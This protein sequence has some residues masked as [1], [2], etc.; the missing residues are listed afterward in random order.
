MPDPA[1]LRG[2][3]AVPPGRLAAYRIAVQVL[4]LAAA[5]VV[6]WY[7]SHIPVQVTDSLGNM[8]EARVH[9]Y[10]ALFVDQLLAK[11]FLRPLLWIQIKGAYDLAAGH[12][13]LTFKTIHT[14]QLVAAAVLLVR[15]CR[16]QSFRDAAY[17]P[18]ILAVLFGVH[19]FEGTVREAHPINSFLSVVVAVLAAMN[20][21]VSRPAWWRDALA[22]LLLAWMALVVETGL[23]VAVAVVAGWLV[24]LRGVSRW[25]VAGCVGLVAAYALLRFGL[26]AN[27]LPGLVERST[28]FGFGVLDP[29]ELIARFGE[30]RWQLYA[31]NVLA[32]L[33]TV[34][35]SE[36]RGGVFGLSKRVMD[37][38]EIPWWMVTDVA[39][40]ALTTLVCA[41]WLA[42]AVRRWR[43]GRLSVADQLGLVGCAVL[44]ANAVL[45]YGYT[46]D[47]IMSAGGGVFAVIVCAALRPLDAVTGGAWRR[48]AV[49]AVVAVMATGW[50]VRAAAL[51]VTLMTEAFKTRNDWATVWLWLEAQ[52]ID[53]SAP[54]ADALVM[55]MRADALKRPV[56]HPSTPVGAI[57]DRR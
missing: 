38:D 16:V 22:I 37:G 40:A 11:G 7:V 14:L 34:L 36:P 21:S 32:S 33:M 41:V 20:L 28:G 30:Q 18:L 45:S 5:G 31:Y 56:P 15:L 1:S 3:A 51:P 50:A 6:A 35:F 46:K 26:T 29:P 8:L 25:G 42:G 43:L 17:V 10:R 12:Y 54:G 48:V 47:V 24:G 53:A 44:A 23:L 13:W 19:T 52:R 57:L 55:A 39:T 2:P 27:G 9:T 4:G 49:A